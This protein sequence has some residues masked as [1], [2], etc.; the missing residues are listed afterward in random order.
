MTNQS[1]VAQSACYYEI[2]YESNSFWLFGLNF[3]L[4]VVAI[5]S[6]G[7]S[8]FTNPIFGCSTIFGNLDFI[9]ILI[10]KYIVESLKALRKFSIYL[11]PS[12]YYMLLINYI[13][14]L[15]IFWHS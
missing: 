5:R 1:N 15:K 10:T 8:I 9:Q 14:G 11:F 6:F 4:I 13:C 3:G 7:F 2:A 12:F